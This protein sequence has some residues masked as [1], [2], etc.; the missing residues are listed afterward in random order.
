MNRGLAH[1]SKLVDKQ[2]KVEECPMNKFI[3]YIVSLFI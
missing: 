3:G 2:F 1:F